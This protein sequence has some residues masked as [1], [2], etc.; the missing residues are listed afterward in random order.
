MKRILVL[1]AAIVFTAFISGYIG[2][3]LGLRDG[4]SLSNTEA[5]MAV[6]SY[7][8]AHSAGDSA[9]AHRVIDSY[10]GLVA[11]YLI[12]G[13]HSFPLFNTFP[14]MSDKSLANLR[15]AWKHP[16]RT[17]DRGRY[18]SYRTLNQ[19]YEAKFEAIEP[20]ADVKIAPRFAR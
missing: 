6:T 12:D 7:H 17:F 1:S 4:V 14:F 2:W 20:S 3:Y 16:S 10:T 15:A 5:A 19:D 8:L 18:Y 13:R 11:C 9:T